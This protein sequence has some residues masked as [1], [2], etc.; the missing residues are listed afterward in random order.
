MHDK[1]LLIPDAGIVW[2]T[3]AN[4]T[5]GSWQLSLNATLRSTSHPVSITLLARFL[6]HWRNARAVLPAARS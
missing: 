3:T 5:R 4:M 2:F 6:E 1:T